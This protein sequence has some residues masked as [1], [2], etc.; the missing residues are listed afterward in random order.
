MKRGR[1]RQQVVEEKLDGERRSCDFWNYWNWWKLGEK[2]KPESSMWMLLLAGVLNS[3]LGSSAASWDQSSSDI[4][5]SCWLRPRLHAFFSPRLSGSS[6]LTLDP[7]ITGWPRT[8]FHSY[9]G[10]T[11]TRF[12]LHGNKWLMRSF[13]C[14]VEMGWR[15]TLVSRLFLKS[16]ICLAYVRVYAAC[17]EVNG[18]SSG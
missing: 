12:P 6:A 16:A 11:L 18:G 2:E 17:W 7:E 1:S 15:P 5:A 14:Q 8:L 13:A 4:T 3:A 10:E 9:S